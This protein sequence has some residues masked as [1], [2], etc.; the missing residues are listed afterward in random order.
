M[1]QTE[2][3]FLSAFSSGKEITRTGIHLP[4]TTNEYAANWL[5]DSEATGSA[6]IVKHVVC[7]CQHDKSRTR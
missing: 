5:S 3:R 6:E 2:G 1:A 4:S 7:L